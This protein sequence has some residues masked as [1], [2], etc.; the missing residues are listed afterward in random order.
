MSQTRKRLPRKGEAFGPETRFHRVGKPG[1]VRL[2]AKEGRNSTAILIEIRRLPAILPLLRRAGARD[3]VDQL[4]DREKA[5]A[6]AGPCGALRRAAGRVGK[7]IAPRDAPRLHRHLLGMIARAAAVERGSVDC[8]DRR[9]V[10]MRHFMTAISLA[11][12]AGRHGAIADF[13]GPGP[14]IRRRG[15]GRIA[16][17]LA[18]RDFGALRGLGLRLARGPA[19]I[20]RRA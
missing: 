17:L 12:L 6:G 3:T 7:D 8:I 5:G 2:P 10:I 15:C 19:V 20:G 13:L 18:M 16:A 1:S 4:V 9:L 11:M 14:D